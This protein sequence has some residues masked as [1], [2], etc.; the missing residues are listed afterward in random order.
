M[1]QF[2]LPAYLSCRPRVLSYSQPNERPEPR[3][4][5]PRKAKMNRSPLCGF[6]GKLLRVRALSGGMD[7]RDWAQQVFRQVM[8]NR[9]V[10]VFRYSGQPKARDKVAQD[11]LGDSLGH[12]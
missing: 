5:M 1:Y 11:A 9:E 10:Q 6:K 2:I 7:N 8:G 3:S 4:G 12:H